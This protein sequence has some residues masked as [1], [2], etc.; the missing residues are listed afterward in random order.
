MNRLKK[1]VNWVKDNLALTA[2]ITAAVAGAVGT[3]LTPILGASLG[4]DIQT[5]LQ[6]LSG[7]LLAIPTFHVS[8][9]ATARAKLKMASGVVA[10]QVGV[11]LKL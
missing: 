5:I 8:T 2:T 3:T 1:I 4:N 9:V 6:T 10:N 11:S 7:L